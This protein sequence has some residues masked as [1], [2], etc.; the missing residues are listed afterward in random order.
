MPKVSFSQS[1]KIGLA[2]KYE[3]EFT[4]E[5]NPNVDKITSLFSSTPLKIKDTC[6]A[7]DPFIVEKE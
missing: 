2:F 7:D 1:Q 3:I 6:K 4:D 5:I